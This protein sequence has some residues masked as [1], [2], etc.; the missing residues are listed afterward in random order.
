M[1]SLSIVTVWNQFIGFAI[2]FLIGLSALIYLV[3]TPVD[4]PNTGVYGCWNEVRSYA[5][6]LIHCN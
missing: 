2:P 4:S 3:W 1:G 5:G 6:T